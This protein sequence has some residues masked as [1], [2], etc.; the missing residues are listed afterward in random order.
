MERKST[1]KR[2]T[3]ETDIS[4]EIILE[5]E[6]EAKINT[7][8]SFFDHMLEHIARHGN[9]KINISAIGDINVD[10]HHTVEDVGIVFGNALVEALGEKKGINR[11]GWASIP[12]DE[13]L[14]NVSID[15]SGRACLVYNV[16]FKNDKI[17]N[18]DV[19]LIREFFQALC[20]NAKMTLHINVPYGD[21][22][23]HVAEA[24]FKA[25]GKA[26][27][28]ATAYSGLNDIPSTKGIL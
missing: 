1:I 18:F 28:T 17:G 6:E 8:I 3:K 23:H 19:E 13:A 9:V 25:F 7:Q 16:I 12:M 24:I 27:R 15:F 4:F 2:K 21:N 10:F 20:Q 22:S 14:A 5:K 26:L 11:Y